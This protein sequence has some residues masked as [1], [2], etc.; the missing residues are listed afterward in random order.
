MGG[1]G[2]G[3][4]GG[5]GG[6]RREGGGREEEVVEGF[7]GPV[8]CPCLFESSQAFTEHCG[9]K[10]RE[11]LDRETVFLLR[12]RVRVRQGDSLHSEGQR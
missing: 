6:V 7:S 4:G 11:Q 9:D 5:G 1:W 3:G 12:V 10:D 2:G 8:T